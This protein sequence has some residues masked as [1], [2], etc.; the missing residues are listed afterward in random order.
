MS[1]PGR[2]TVA[3]AMAL[4]L[5]D[6]AVSPPSLSSAAGTSAGAHRSHARRLVVRLRRGPSFAQP[7]TCGTP[8]SPSFSGVAGDV[9]GGFHAGALAGVTNEACDDASAIAGGS[10]NL[11]GNGDNA[12]NSFI[13]GGSNNGITGPTAF[14]G[15][16]TMNGGEALDSFVGAGTY[17]DVTGAGAFVG[18]GG[19]AYSAWAEDFGQSGPPTVYSNIASGEDAFVGAGDL[20]Q[21]SGTGSFIG[22]GGSA[23]ANKGVTSAV[24]RVSG[25]DSFIG[26]G[27][28]NYVGAS[29]AFLGGGLSDSIAASATNAVI[30]G[31][32]GNNVSGAYG[33]V[34]GGYH[35]SAT[36]SGAAVGGGSS[37]SATGQYATIPGGYLNAANGTG[38]FAAGT[39]AKARHN[40]AFVWSDNNGTAELQSTAA[41]QFVARAS[42]GFYL[43]TD[44]TAKT[45]VK[46]NPGSGTWSSL[47]DRTMK[48][49]V[50]ALDDAAVLAKVAALP[51]SEWSYISEHGVR[52]VGP[53]AQ[54]FY[55]AFRVGEDD[56]HITSIDEDGVALAAIKALHAENRELHREN[57][58]LR[59]RLTRQDARL[60]ALERA[61]AALAAR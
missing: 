4:M 61:V 38:S 57:H 30:A 14:I 12:Q 59:E 52:H 24:N 3:V 36:A 7:D 37:S 10:G 54:D 34:S 44:A 46:L 35:N 51:V 18:G 17:N 45:G 47:S 43:F 13:G 26:A 2:V 56:R 41:Y 40:G 5:A 22:A 11:I 15:A 60:A 31:G 42:G 27:D 23:Y 29:E 1:F 28:E 55:A 9:A 25:I 58:G 49:G 20:N 16:G 21:V 50:V 33:A 8:G 53:M 19:D 6:L 32:D 48:T 39:Q